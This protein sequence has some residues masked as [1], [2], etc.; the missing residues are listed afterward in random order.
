MKFMPEQDLPLLRITQSGGAHTNVVVDK[1]R[2]TIGRSGTCDLRLQ[3]SF[4]SRHHAEIV[5]EEG[6]FLLRDQ[7]SKTGT[8]VNG[9]RVQSCVLKHADEIHFGKA[10]P[11][12]V[13]FILDRHAPLEEG[14]RFNTS[15]LALSLA[16]RDLT[17]ISKLL[18]NA[19]LF[20]AGLPL[21]DILDIILDLA[22]E[23]SKAERGFIVLRSEQS[24]EI[25]FERGRDLNNASLSEDCFNVSRSVLKRVI[26][27]GSKVTMMD[28]KGQDDFAGTE[29]VALLELRTIVCLPLKRFEAQET[30]KAKV[31]S[32]V[33]GALYLDSRTATEKFSKMSEGILDSLAG[34][35][36][37]VIENA[38]LLRE[39]QN[40]ERLELELTTAQQIQESLLPKIEGPYEFFE[41]YGS[42]IPS[43]HIGGDYYDLIPLA[44]GAYAFAIAD[45]AG[46]GI[47]AA[48]LSSMVQGMLFAEAQR[49]SSLTACVETVNRYLVQR[50][51]SNRFITLFYGKLSPDG[52]LRFVNG[53]HNPPFL[54]RMNTQVEQLTAPGMVVG[55]F[56]SAVYEEVA[57][58]LQ[59][60][61]LICLYTDGITE[62]RN[63]KGE[64]F[65]EDRLID[66][67]RVNQSD[68]LEEIAVE[69]LDSVSSH[70]SGLSQGDDLT[71]LLVRYIGLK[72]DGDQ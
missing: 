49:H 45:V 38:R 61:D 2:F 13:T 7:N 30:N 36:T 40:K 68:P 4:V 17:N 59:P 20:N 10:N 62:A 24:G 70:A 31:S 64:F 55:V 33:I 9:E 37:V 57:I 1:Q 58:L 5:C 22:I 12:S 8:Y 53:G 16:G 66:I 3:D 60:G 6:H 46:K 51:N 50:T 71:L 65:G 25:R 41:A 42:N 44:D 34:D 23:V 18:E 14:P 63:L 15:S 52:E 27:T 56:A 29:S 21:G 19:R 54:F 72:S 28:H 35:V 11:Q 67:L 47:P 32:Q 43:R 48:I 39:L 69:V 26:D